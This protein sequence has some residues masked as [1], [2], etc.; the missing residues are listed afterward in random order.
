MMRLHTALS[1]VVALVLLAAPGMAQGTP[2]PNDA[3]ALRLEGEIV[4]LRY[5]GGL[6]FDGRIRNPAAVRSAVPNVVR[7]G[8]IV[9]QVIVFNARGRVALEIAAT[10][11]ASGQAF[12]CESDRAVR[13]RPIV[14]HSS[15]LSRSL[16][17]Q[18]VYDR[19]WDWVISV[20]DQPRTGVRI[21]PQKDGP[22]SRT[23]AFEAHGSEIVLR[24]RPRF[25]QKH[26]GLGFYQPWTYTIWPRPVVGWC[27][28]FAFFNKITES[29]V[30]RTADVMADVLLPYG[31]EYLQIDDG[32]QRDTGLPELWLKPNEKFPGGLEA[33][34]SYIRKK[35]LKPGIWTNAA[36]P[37]TDYA[38]QHKD[39]F[40]LDAE[41]NLARGNWINHVVDASIPAALD[42]LVRP[43]YRELRA[44]GWEYFKLDALRHLRYEGYNTYRDHLA[45]RG[46]TPG[47]ALRSY[48]AAVRQ[49]IG[50]E[51]FLLACWGVRPELIGLVDACRIGTDGFSYAGLA[52]YNSFNNVVWRNDPDHI[53]LSETEAWRSTMVTSLTGSL[54]LLT[55]K[56]ERYRTPFADPAQRAAPVLV[57]MPA[58]LYDV[59][60]SRSSLLARADSEVS[61]R[62]PKPFDAGLVPA[63]D[64]YLLDVSRPFES[65]EVL[66]RTGGEAGSIR[67][68]ELGLD[69]ARTYL[70]F[71][72]WQRKYCGA[73]TGSFN[74]GQLP[75][76]YNSQVF[77]IRERLSRPQVVATNRHITGGGV[78]L[79]DVAWSDGL[80]TGRSRVVGGDPYEIFLTEPAGWQ[81]SGMECEGGTP[82]EAERQGEIV[83][84]GCRSESGREILWRARFQKKPAPASTDKQPG[85]ARRDSAARSL[86]GRMGVRP[87]LPRGPCVWRAAWQERYGRG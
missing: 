26:R 29:D 3:A 52:Q 58:L 66:G 11:T 64:L 72:F 17:N 15:G 76:K 14:R 54:F 61:G 19:K 47:D 6:I 56:P 32:Y 51:R 9:D 49:Q 85:N 20:D 25:Y 68:E 46:V 60:A 10:V 45:R 50:P 53:E 57:T 8:D 86:S 35:G 87:T 77:I 22:S 27:S 67:F 75:A 13:G 34:A 36:F 37:Q 41:G 7:T 18:A 1:V 21:V 48:V 69:P 28:W 70:V 78:D 63:A 30:M 83:K 44:M 42:A 12:P 62:D 2:P 23:F 39:W 59:D 82:L 73:F 65:W 79:I 31:Y 55:D 84:T 4:Q 71:E 40:V 81:L 5:N 74:P 43:I 24:F 38:T 80:L 16:L 33:L